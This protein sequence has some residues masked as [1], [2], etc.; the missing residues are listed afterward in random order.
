MKSSV[1]LRIV[2]A[3]LMAGALAAVVY[4]YL[5]YRGEASPGDVI[6]ASGRIEGRITTL[7]A[8][9]PAHVAEIKIDEG[10]RVAAGAILAV[11]DDETQRAV[12]L[13]AEKSVASLQEQLR[14]ADTEIAALEKQTRNHI[15][16]AEAAL[17]E[18]TAHVEQAEA[19]LALWQR[20]RDRY[21]A[22]A[23]RDVASE[24]KLDDTR[25][26]AHAGEHALDAAKA[27]VLRS[28]RLLDA[29]RLEWDNVAVKKAQREVLAK[30][31]EEEEA[32]LK[33][34]QSYVD[35]FTIRA[36]IAA[37]VLSRTIELGERVNA[38]T[39]LFT[40]VPLDR[41]YVKV[42]I[43]E[44][45][46]GKIALGQPARI[47]VD[48]FPGRFFA[49]RVA[50]VSQEAEF[51]PKNVETKEERVKLVFAVELDIAANPD[52]VLKPGMPA[53]AE[54]DLPNFAASPAPRS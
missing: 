18:N 2:V 40:L 7:T 44:P 16:S 35:D 20:E 38:G 47:T 34:Q 51:T 12:V 50:R 43:P 9:S 45:D 24:Q 3:L 30:Q 25:T 28:Q 53:D 33:Q 22:L 42:Y 17:S 54:I 52:G 26:R 49:A 10:E 41:L 23:K 21:E 46:I 11:L 13:S 5:R 4:G 27:A 8:K 6:V 19:N 32:V 1:F 39:P 36:P 15:E 29:A 48:S 31:I 37:T 14:A